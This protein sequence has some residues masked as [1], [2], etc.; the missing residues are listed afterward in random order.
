MKNKNNYDYLLSDLTKLAGGGKKTMTILKKKKINNI[1]DI[2]FKLPKSYINR[3]NR[4]KINQL[5]I[6]WATGSAS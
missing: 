6:R 1:F 3:G 4:L 2:L 5:Q